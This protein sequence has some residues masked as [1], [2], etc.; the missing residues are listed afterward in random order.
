M[1][2]KK[3]SKSKA[4]PTIKEKKDSSIGVSRIFLNEWDISFLG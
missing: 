1:N 4:N 2:T 3:T